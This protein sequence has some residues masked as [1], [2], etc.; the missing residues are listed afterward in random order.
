VRGTQDLRRTLLF[1]RK[2]LVVHPESP[3]PS[4]EIST[5]GFRASFTVSL[6][7]RER[8]GDDPRPAS[9]ARRSLR[10]QRSESPDS[11]GQGDDGMSRTSAIGRCKTISQLPFDIAK[12]GTYPDDKSQ[13]GPALARASP[14][15]ESHRR[16]TIRVIFRRP[17]YP[18]PLSPRV[19]CSHP[20][21]RGTRRPSAAGPG[22]A[23]GGRRSNGSDELPGG[24]GRSAR[25][26]TRQRWA[27]THAGVGRCAPVHCGRIISAGRGPGPMGRPQG[28]PIGDA[29]RRRVG[30]GDISRRAR[31]PRG[32]PFG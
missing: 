20:G 8:G 4:R 10:L 17:S 7:C 6:L 30:P 5:H 32:R 27:A 15:P 23:L 1:G 24:S 14:R 29:D 13:H 31:A 18:R 12:A 19:C 28:L 21:S 22:A 26:A 25:P 11:T 3:S 16:F 2:P 9:F